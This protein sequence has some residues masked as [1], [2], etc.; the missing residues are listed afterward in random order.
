[1]N[2]RIDQIWW[3]LRLTYGLVAFLAGLDKFFN[4]L[5]NWESYLA[6]VAGNLLPVGTTSLM[7]V[8]GVV[9]ML[10]GVL[11]LTNW[12]RVG[13]Y[14]ASGWLLLIALTLLLTGSHF[15]VAVRDV[16]MA[17][18]AWTLAGLTEVRKPAEAG[19]AAGS[20]KRSARA[21]A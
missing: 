11:I 13:G 10:V 15:D 2:S 12:T 20:V 16:A 3:A 6:P 1:M 14:V 7:R 9:E 5:V 18:G 4:L 17:V 8:V 21:E 19:V